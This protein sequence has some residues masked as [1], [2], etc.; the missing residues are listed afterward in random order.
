MNQNLLPIE[1]SRKT[2][3]GKAV[4]IIL[5][6]RVELPWWEPTEDDLLIWGPL[7]QFVQDY[8]KAKLDHYTNWQ[9]RRLMLSYNADK[10]MTAIHPFIKE[11]DF[12]RAY[13]AVVIA[14]DR[15]STATPQ[16]MKTFDEL[17]KGTEEP[18]AAA[19]QFPKKS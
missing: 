16:Q 10:I 7:P 9:D 17:M 4:E 2:D 19:L 14:L 1:D 15:F 11:G 12:Q 8:N 6:P 18:K 3:V 5:P 13:D